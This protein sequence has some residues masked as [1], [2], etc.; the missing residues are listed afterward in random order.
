LRPPRPARPLVDLMPT[1]TFL[2]SCAWV[3]AQLGLLALIFAA[4]ALQRGASPRGVQLLGVFLLV[5][6]GAVGLASVLALGRGTTPSPIP[7]PNARLIRS[8]IY[9]YVRHP[10]YTCLM[11][12]SAGWAALW[13]SPLAL[14]G[15]VGL[16]VFLRAKA[17]FEE[18]LLLARFSEYADYAAR[19]PRFLPRIA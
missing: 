9:A 15:L 17:Q 13:N 4:P 14:A 2:R 7:R 11:L 10:M 18:C 1:T 5:L 8:G 19:T 16:I 12:A 6:G 3:L